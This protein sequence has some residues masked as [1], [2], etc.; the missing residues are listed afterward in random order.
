MLTFELKAKSMQ[1]EWNGYF[2]GNFRVRTKGD[3]LLSIQVPGATQPLTHTITVEEPDLEKSITRPDHGHLYQLA[4]SARGILGRVDEK[5]RA[6]LLRALKAPVNPDAKEQQAQP[7]GE[8]VN[9]DDVRLYFPL[10]SGSDAVLK[11]MRRSYRAEKY[12][13]WLGLFWMELAP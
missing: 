12:L 13:G 5:K 8:K 9:K 1:G 7:E 4:T 3:Y 6:E 2:A 11:A 10:Q